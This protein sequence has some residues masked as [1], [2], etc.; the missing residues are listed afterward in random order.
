MNKVIEALRCMA[1]HGGDWYLGTFAGVWYLSPCYAR[2]D[3]H[4]YVGFRQD[5]LREFLK[6]YEEI[7]NA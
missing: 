1:D 3:S 6:H 4:A 5:E 2:S 7:T